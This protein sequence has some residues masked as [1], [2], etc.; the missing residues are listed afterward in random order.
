LT[1]NFI[2]EENK[3]RG[4]EDLDVAVKDMEVKELTVF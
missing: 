1:T 3:T 4:S 2:T